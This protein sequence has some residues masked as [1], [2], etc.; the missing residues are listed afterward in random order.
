LR[1]TW[2]AE[3]PDDVD[4][5]DLNGGHALPCPP[6]F[7]GHWGVLWVELVRHCVSADLRVRR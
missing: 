7:V 5:A 2:S 4:P 6:H 1:G 3:R